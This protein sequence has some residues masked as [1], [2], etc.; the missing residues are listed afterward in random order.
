MKNRITTLTIGIIVSMLVGVAFYTHSVSASTTVG[1]EISKES[2]NIKLNAP[3]ISEANKPS[4]IT[5]QLVNGI[6]IEIINQQVQDNFLLVDVCFQLPSDSDWLLSTYPDD[7]ILTVGNET[8][9]HSGFG[10]IDTK[11]N[12]SGNKTRC[13]RVTF[14]ISGQEDLSKFVITINHL[15]TSIPE[16]PD[17]DKAQARN[18]T[19]ISV[20]F[21]GAPRK[22]TGA[23][24]ALSCT[25]S[26]SPVSQRTSSAPA[27]ATT[28][29]LQRAFAEAC[30]RSSNT[31]YAGV[32]STTVAEVP[33]VRSSM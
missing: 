3:I 29:R 25:G 26:H 21:V 23:A 5:K 12:A 11:T 7:V 19:T 17:C 20:L 9:P 15:V 14:Q 28:P 30:T 22:T 18:R 33:A 24:S 32:C 2:T 6:E 13:D 27:P 16:N 4:N 1:F 8:I 31:V 10:E